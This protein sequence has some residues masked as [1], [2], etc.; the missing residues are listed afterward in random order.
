MGLNA[1]SPYDRPAA[2]EYAEYYTGYVSLV[3]D[4][5]LVE[6]LERTGREL[7]QELERLPESKGDLAYGPGKWTIKEVIL[8]VCDAE[9][10]FGYRAM[11]I[12]R[13][14]TLSLPSFD[15]NAW[16]PMSGAKDRTLAS[17]IEEFQAVRAA[18]VALFR[19]LPAEA[20]TRRGTASNHPVTVRALAWI[21]AGHM[22][23]HRG[24]LRERYLA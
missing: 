10:V 4:G 22:L 13:G 1:R 18:S 7:V 11:R 8:H 17:L 21:V 9:R 12:A 3:P 14:D 16:V 5:D 15:E 19:N 20:A 23:H 2:D 6:T 24:I